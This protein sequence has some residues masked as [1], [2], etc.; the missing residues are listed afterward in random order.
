[1]ALIVQKFGGTSVA[2]ATKIR[3]AAARAVA[4]KR[5]GNQVVMVVSARGHKT[6]ELIELA[7]EVS[8]TP[9]PREMDMLLATGRA[10]IGRP[11][12]DGHPG[13]GRAGRQPH[14]RPDRHRD[15]FDAHQGPHSQRS[16]PS[17]FAAS[18]TP[19]KSS[20]PPVFRG[21]TTTSTSRR[22]AAAAATR[23]PR[24]WPPSCGADEC[25]IYTDVEGV[26]TTDPRLIAGGPQN[27]SDLLRRNARAGQ[28]GRRRHA[29]AVDRVRQEVSRPAARAPG[30]LA[31]ERG[32]L[33]RPAGRRH[34]RG[35]AAW[36]WPGTR[37][38]S[39]CATFP[40]VPA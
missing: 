21:S 39:A 11:D 1:M 5:A 19:E 30:V 4:A 38:A 7:A 17:G 12:G 34:A 32:T 16:T 31:P 24:P 29:L 25:E 20:S 36:R 40:T 15:R 8:A 2:D 23:R 6:D 9:S 37:P 22:W 26:F 27:R 3:A 18:S 10:G 35:D 14:G 33:D 28:P 13:P